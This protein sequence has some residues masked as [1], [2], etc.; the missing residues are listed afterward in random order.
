MRLFL[1]YH[2]AFVFICICA[3]IFCLL[4]SSPSAR[5]SAVSYSGGEAFFCPYNIQL[6]SPFSCLSVAFLRSFQLVSKAVDLLIVFNSYFVDVAFPF[7]YSSSL[8]LFSMF[9]SIVIQWSL[10]F[11]FFLP[12]KY[13]ISF[14]KESCNAVSIVI[15]QG[16]R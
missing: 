12:P 13:Y 2:A 14:R 4:A 3:A 6:F 15:S 11:T 8:Q 9:L 10:V 7:Y 5:S 16:Q 1:S